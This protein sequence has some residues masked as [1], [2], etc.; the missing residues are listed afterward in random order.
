MTRR[1]AFL[2]P[3]AAA[4]AHAKENLL[5]RF[6][7]LSMPAKGPQHHRVFSPKDA[8]GPP[9]VILHELP[10]LSPSDL[11][12]GLRIAGEGFTPYLPLI[13]GKPGEYS[14]YANSLRVCLGRQINCS[15]AN[16]QNPCIEWLRPLCD[17]VSARHGGGPLGVIGMCLTG[18][19]PISLIS[20]ACVKGVVLSQPA[21]PNIPTVAI[22]VPQQ[23]IDFARSQRRDVPMLGLRFATD[24]ICPPERFVTLRKEF[25]E[26]FTGMEIEPQPGEPQRDSHAMHAVLTESY[27]PALPLVRGAYDEVI[28]FMRA[29]IG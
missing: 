12:L 20:Q 3:F 26:Q 11:R 27:D 24:T 7:E 17:E 23:D 21:P 8:K 6:M 4:L 18:A 2:M 10:G 25:R 22:G 13:F 28:T 1:Q 16:K 9:V 15:A 5:T 29:R 14:F 19:L